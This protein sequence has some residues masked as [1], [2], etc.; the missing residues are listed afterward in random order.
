MARSWLVVLMLFGEAKV[1]EAFLVRPAFASWLAFPSTKGGKMSSWLHTPGVFVAAVVH[2]VHLVII[3][4][5]TH[6]GSIIFNPL[7]GLTA[8]AVAP[9]WG[10]TLDKD[11]IPAEALHVVLREEVALRLDLAQVINVLGGSTKLVH[12]DPATTV[13]LQLGMSA[14]LVFLVTVHHVLGQSSTSHTLCRAHQPLISVLPS[15]SAW[16]LVN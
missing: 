13:V 16:V 9:I 5:D 2:A 12:K 15:F 4:L 7:A 11:F 3:R 8:P 14:L 6:T 1:A 10:G